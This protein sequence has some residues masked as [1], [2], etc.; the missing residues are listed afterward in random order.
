MQPFLPC[1]MIIYSMYYPTRLSN[2]S[3]V[4]Y[5]KITDNPHSLFHLLT[6]LSFELKLTL[7]L[8]RILSIS[9]TMPSS[10]SPGHFK[11]LYFASARSYVG[12]DDEEFKA[13]MNLA[14]LIPRL[15]ELYPGIATKILESCMVTINLDY[16]DI[17][18]HGEAH[19]S[20][21]AGDEVAIIP[22]VSAG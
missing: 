22:P 2:A 4:D 16:V 21:E 6:P 13:P 14:D 19:I 15:D 11:L 17:P 12:K 1:M 5:T 7:V 10:A 8:V 18:K 3:T 20:I 9:H